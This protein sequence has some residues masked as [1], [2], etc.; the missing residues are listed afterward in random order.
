[1]GGAC[2]ANT[3]VREISEGLCGILSEN[4]EEKYAIYR[5]KVEVIYLSA[6]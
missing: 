5:D 1:M 3:E 2:G 4:M 6:E